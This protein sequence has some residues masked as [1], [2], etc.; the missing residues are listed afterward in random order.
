MAKTRKVALISG[1][2]G[3]DGSHLADLLVKKGYEV[4][5]LLRRSSTFNKQNIDH[6]RG[7]IQ[8]H[9]ADLTDPFSLIWALKKSNP[10][11]I[12]NLGAQSHV[13]I[14]W[15]I[16]YYTAQVDAIGVLNLLEAVRVLGIKPK[17]YQASTS[18]LFS[19]REKGPQDEKTPKDPISPYGTSKLFGFQIAKNYRDAYSM[20]ICN[21][22][23]FNHDS[24]RRGDNF[25]T[26]KI[27][28]DIDNLRLGNIH[29]K[30]DFGYSP[31]YME[32]AWKM[33]QQ[34]K[35]DDYVVATGETTSI[36]QFAQYVADSYGIPLQITIDPEYNRPNDVPVLKGNASKAR[37]KLGW[38]PKVK[39][40]ELAEIMTSYE[41]RKL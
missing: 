36:K 14:S 2:T 19:G 1:C 29:T 3:M 25:V 38:K 15:E 30:R 5:G 37:K 20:F 34:D 12:Y 41:K 21:G 9:Y 4:H 28:N 18:E 6:L 17:I 33:L 16:P 39:A 11:E 32:V 13:Q 31:E 26:K 35:P 27:V 22:I 7:K 23:L 10:T 24:E 8:Y 40:K